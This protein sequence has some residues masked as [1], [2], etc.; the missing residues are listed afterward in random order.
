MDRRR[1]MCTKSG[2]DRFA[3]RKGGTC[4]KHGGAS[5]CATVGCTK[6][7]VFSR[8]C[9][10][11]G[12]PKCSFV[13]E[14]GKQCTSYVWKPS[15]LTCYKHCP[16]QRLKG[17]HYA[18]VRFSWLKSRHLNTRRNAEEAVAQPAPAPAP[19][20][21]VPADLVSDFDFSSLLGMAD[22][23]CAFDA[24]TDTKEFVQFINGIFASD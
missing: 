1:P 18:R 24:K 7:A 20:T 6:A 8:M 13:E 5:R 17:N 15:L 19:T 10:E 12:W 22:E 9:K 4:F 14:S 11:C 21:A 3:R 23:L 2:C 16:D